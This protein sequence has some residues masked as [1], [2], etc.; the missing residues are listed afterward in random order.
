MLSPPQ[1]LC[2]D[3][4]PILL[5][6]DLISK[7]QRDIPPA[8]VHCDKEAV[9][10]TARRL[11]QWDFYYFRSIAY[12][13]F[14]VG[15]TWQEVA[16]KMMSVYGDFSPENATYYTWFC[17]WK[18][19][20]TVAVHLGSSGRPPITGLADSIREALRICETA[21]TKEIA[22]EL[23]HDS[24]TIKMRLLGEMKMKKVS[25][26]WVPHTL[27][28][29]QKQLRCEL[30]RVIKR[31]LAE[32]QHHKFS[33]VITGDETWVFLENPPGSRWVDADAPRPEAVKE[34]IS[35]KKVMVTVFF[36]G[37]RFLHLCVQD[38]GDHV[39]AATFSSLILT[40][41]SN[42]ISAIS[43]P[44]PTP[45]YLHFDNASSHRARTSTA[46]AEHDFTL[47]PHP[48]YSPDL[49]PADFF[50]FGTLKKKLSGCVF[51]NQ[52]DVE[53]KL[54]ELLPKISPEMLER[55][56]HNWMDRC[57][58]IREKGGEYY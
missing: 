18:K 49:A 43:P 33:N 39:T 25:I 44:L 35:S 37:Q 28:T 42:T 29:S 4:T 50:L 55:T 47:L 41:L 27:T 30:A 24:R 38:I 48:P 14:N 34:S 19:D 36:S 23:G 5:A 56:F 53:R 46:Q 54:K 9:L 8:L 1:E 31:V 51:K 32:N 12:H 3:D 52:N 16:V 57:D 2:F 40:P 11:T 58:K 21:S 7:R 20:K 26:R 13:Y 10:E 22:K 6:R 45:R 17:N 15:K